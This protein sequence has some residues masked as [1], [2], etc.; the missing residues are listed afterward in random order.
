MPMQDDKPSKLM[1]ET[2]EII[3]MAEDLSRRGHRAEAAFFAAIAAGHLQAI[4]A[5]ERLRDA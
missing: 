5:L 1:R 2:G 3:R 4:R